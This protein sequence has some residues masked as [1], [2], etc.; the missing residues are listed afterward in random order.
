MRKIL[1]S[2]CL[3]GEQ[4]RY[5]GKHSLI[6]HPIIARWKAEGRLVKI[7][8]ECAGGLPT[9]R[10]PSEI[11]SKFPILITSQDA[12]DVTPEFLTGAEKTLELAKQEHVCCALMKARSPSCG[13]TQI[14]DGS[15]SGKLVADSG[16]AASELLRNGIPVFNEHQLEDMFRFIE[17]R[18]STS[19]FSET[20]TG[21]SA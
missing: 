1:I 8:P 3:F 19:V 6:N 16:I 4:V 9:P 5:D 2:A 14:Y 15:F 20:Q 10:S 21:K 11:Q 13:N 18:Q 17:A 7:C 12:Q